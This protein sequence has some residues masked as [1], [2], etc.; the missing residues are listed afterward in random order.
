MSLTLT[1]TE[2]VQAVPGNLFNADRLVRIANI[3]ETRGDVGFTPGGGVL[4]D[5]PATKEERAA[6]ALT[7]YSAPRLTAL[8]EDRFAFN[9]NKNP[10]FRS[11]VKSFTVPRTEPGYRLVV[12]PLQGRLT[13]E[14]LR[15][16]A[17]SAKAF[18]HDEIRITAGVSVRLPNVPTA[19]LRPLFKAL[20]TAGLLVEQSERLAA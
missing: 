15:V 2:N 7:G 20:V 9:M 18:G 16:I 11:F 12:I 1:H 14:Q 8:P 3:A 5:T 4:F 13:P 6:L 10:A 17:H 19:L